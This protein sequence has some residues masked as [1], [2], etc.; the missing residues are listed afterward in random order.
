VLPSLLGGCIL[1]PAADE[2]KGR[3]AGGAAEGTMTLREAA[4]RA[5]RHVGT[6]LATEY[7]NEPSYGAIAGRQFDS[8]TPE[9]QMK[10]EAIEPRKGAFA[11]EGGDELVAFAQENGMRVRGHTLVWHSQLAPWVKG[12]SGEALHSAMIDHVK[13]VAGHYAGRVA[14]WDVVNEALADGPT[15]ALRSDSPFTALGP[16]FIDDAFRA[17]HQADANALLFYNDYEIERP[18]APKTEAALRLVKRL[19]EAG[20]PIGG[21]GFQM[22]VDPR[23]W[24]SADE[25]R[26]NFERF[27]E[28]GLAVEITEMDVPVGAVAGSLEEKF[29][30]QKAIGHDIVAACVAVPRCTGITVW[31]F[32]DAHT[33]LNDAHWGALRGPLPHYPL[34]FDDDYR[35]KPL[36]Y[37]I[38]DALAAAP[39][40][41]HV[42]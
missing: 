39:T 27:A 16:T 13:A 19:K 10:W 37:G 7:F 15:G 8:L 41:T 3:S 35:A 22:H 4:G 29:A 2:S 42:L 14:Q 23:H 36:Y 21:I 5:H 24:P 18:G 6:A 30:R 28:L 40:P 34:P 20:V 12:L 33:W 17:A 9:N 1:V 25:I 32:T 31:G 38:L 11:F 26:Q